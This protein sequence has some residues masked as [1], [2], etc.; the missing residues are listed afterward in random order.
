VLLVEE[1]LIDPEFD[2]KTE[3]AV[4]REHHDLQETFVTVA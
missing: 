2:R 1:C 3:L 4:H